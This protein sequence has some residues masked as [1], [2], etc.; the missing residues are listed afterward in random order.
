MAKFTLGQKKAWINLVIKR[1]D[2]LNH[3]GDDAD[4][5]GSECNRMIKAIE[6]DLE[7]AEA[8]RGFGPT[9]FSKDIN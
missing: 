3:N 8:T 2:R 9:S 7:I 5:F 1:C 4:C 6:E